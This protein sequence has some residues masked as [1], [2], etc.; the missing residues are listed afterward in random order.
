MEFVL[1]A[2]M[3]PLL[4]PLRS[5]TTPAMMLVELVAASRPDD[6]ELSVE[7][8]ALRRVNWNLSNLHFECWHEDILNC[9]YPADTFE[10]ARYAGIF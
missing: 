10:P 9:R 4:S 7:D 5:I 2:V 6:V 8:L 3:L 1:D